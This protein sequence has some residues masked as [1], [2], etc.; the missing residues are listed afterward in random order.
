MNSRI[1]GFYTED[2]S[3]RLSTVVER[4]DLDAEAVD[5]LDADGAVGETVDGL[6]ENVV[7][8][9]SYPLSVATNFVVDGEDLLVPMA[10][11]ESSVVAAASKGALLARPGGGFTTD[12]DGPYMI[13]Q[14]QVADVSDPT[15]ARQRVLARA[16]EIAAVANDQ[17]VLVSHG[18]GCEDVTVRVVDTPAGETVV[19]HLLVDV[20]DAMGA[21]AVNTMCEAVA[22]VVADATGG[23]VSLRVLSNLADC[24]LARARCRVEPAALVEDEDDPERADGLD[25]ETVRD[26]I[27]EAWAFAAGD[28]YRAATHNKGIM[29]AVDALAVATCNDWRALEAGAHAY[30]AREGY[31]PL[32]TYEVGADGDLVCRIELPVQ[33][34]TVGGAT[35]VHPAGRAAMEVLGVEAADEFAGVVAAL[36]LAENLASLRAL[37]DE[38]IQAGHM[39]LH[40][41]NVARQAGAPAGLVAEVAARMVAEGAV[42]E[43][44]ARELIEVLG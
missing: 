40:A 23:R 24:R 42:R 31:G 41:E 39:K 13:G 7:G 6:S 32:T 18:G 3:E 19:V 26:R 33:A 36:G 37:V 28:P 11:E 22:P 12:T 9:V 15:A 35:A 34:G 1:P 30:A 29:N 20:R 25:G 38:G 5:A 8:S 44:R 2:R 43:S 21:N 27:V 4:C 17:G 14:V 16:D 10:V